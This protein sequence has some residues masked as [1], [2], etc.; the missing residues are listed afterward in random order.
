[1]RNQLWLNVT[2]SQT[3]K[4][5]VVT[6]GASTVSGAW[7]QSAVSTSGEAMTAEQARVCLEYLV[8]ALDGQYPF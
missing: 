8:M 6:A 4:R 1:M 2:W 3:G 7:H 5:W